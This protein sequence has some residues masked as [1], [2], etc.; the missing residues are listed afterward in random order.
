MA[1]VHLPPKFPLLPQH[2]SRIR[3]LEFSDHR[4]LSLLEKCT[5][6]FS[7][8]QI[9]T[10]M[11]RLGLFFHPFSATRLLTAAAV[12]PISNLDYAERVFDQIPHPNLY[13]FNT[14]I[15]AHASGPTP[16]RAFFFFIQLLYQDHLH[17]PNKFT[18]PFLLKATAEL[19]AFGLGKAL[20]G[21]VCKLGLAADVYILNSLVHFYAS[22]LCLDLAHELFL[23][24]PEKDVVSWNS[25]ITAFVHADLPSEALDLFQKMKDEKTCPPNEVTMATVLSACAKKGDLKFGRG[26]CEYIKTEEIKPSLVLSNA[27][28][29]MYTKCASLEDAEELFDKMVVRDSFSWT[30]MLVGF[31]KAGKFNAARQVFDSMSNRD[32]ASWNA[33]IS[34]YEQ[35]DHP[36]E[37]L[38]LFRELQLTDTKPDGVTLVST[39]SACTQLGALD[40]GRWIHAYINKQNLSLNFHLTTS[41]I[42]MYAKC[43]D[44]GKAL[45]VFDSV[46]KKD[47]CVW[48]AM[49]AGLSMHGQG[50]AAVDLFLKMQ[51]AKV[52]P[53]AVTF[54]N[55]LCACS[56]AGLVDTARLFFSQM[57]PVYGIEP[58]VQHYG[59]MVDLLGRAGLFDESMDLIEQMPK[60]ACVS[61]WAALLGACRIHGNLRLGELACKRI[62]EIEPNH[63]GAYVLLSNIYAKFG[64]WEDVSRLRKLMK[65]A[66]VK[67]EPGCSAVEVDGVVHEFLVGDTSHPLSDE[68]YSK[69]A[70]IISRLKSVGYA[71]DS[72]QLIQDVEE[73]EVRE[74]AL[75]SHSEKLAIA[76]GLIT[77]VPPGPIRI[78]KNLRICGDCH[79]AAKLISV[80]Y[81]REIVL[82]DR[83][84]FHHFRN[85][86]CSCK[87]YW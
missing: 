33:L 46:A 79:S 3:D 41:L 56:H 40:L 51:E 35:R 10:Q 66:G 67:K 71:S 4:T 43:G 81:D 48:S 57:L 38:A 60:P 20:H 82:R 77:T 26:V 27:I 47:V 14:L 62:L 73:D 2:S 18:F 74:L 50:Q 64:Q 68:I 8:K 70:E 65:D 59:C 32:I 24:I 15:R 83:Y 30:T 29:D 80:V 16:E 61:V 9:H 22:C 6:A 34:A 75:S 53:N 13:C 11:L 42:D 25:I 55:L 58:Q 72:S 5:D 7:L 85:G 28:L 78:V 45:E 76:F 63:D 54:T 31:A 23:Q 37:A 87:D 12:A 84:R 19:S 49:I 39:L 36:H 17:S 86:D 69:L 21:M 1:T 52:K 44:L